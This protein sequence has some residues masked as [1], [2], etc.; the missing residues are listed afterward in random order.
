MS[1]SIVASPTHQPAKRIFSYCP[2]FSEVKVKV[3]I[4]S[5]V[6]L[7]AN[8]W[9]VAHQAP[10]SMGFSRREYWSGLPFPSPEDLPKPGFE[11]GSPALQADS[12]LSQP[13]PG[14][15]LNSVL[16]LIQYF[17]VPILGKGG[18]EMFFLTLHWWYFFSPLCLWTTCTGVCQTLK[19]QSG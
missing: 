3:L 5:R 17:C 13:P 11:F 15:S 4:A 2:W 14:Q 9:T 10:L 7:L 1:P 16:E 18:N 12:L 8:P 6:W 19:S